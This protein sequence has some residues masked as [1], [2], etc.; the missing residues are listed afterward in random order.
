[1]KGNDRYEGYGVELIEKLAE[2]LEFNFEFRIQEDGK[3]GENKTGEWDGMLGELNKDNADLA[4]TDLTMT[5]EREAA[6]DFTSP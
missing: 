5:A 3:Y 6:F 1:M 4:V 2:L